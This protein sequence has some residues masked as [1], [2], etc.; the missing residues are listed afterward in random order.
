MSTCNY[1]AQISAYHDDALPADVRLKVESHLPSC[2]DCAREL[3]DLRRISNLFL[4]ARTAPA[5]SPL[6]LRDVR[7]VQSVLW[8]EKVLIGTAASIMLI[9][10]SW[11]VYQPLSSNGASP[12]S[13]DGLVLNRNDRSLDVSDPLLQAFVREYGSD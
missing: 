6:R 5:R 9:C 12:S 3:E 7:E 2:S 10:G 11:L 8:F 13:L 4:A 1:H